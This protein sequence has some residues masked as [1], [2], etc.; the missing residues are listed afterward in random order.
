M[1]LKW[2]EKNIFSLVVVHGYP[3]TLIDFFYCLEL[4]F[5]HVNRAIAHLTVCKNQDEINTII[6]G[7]EILCYA[8][9]FSLNKYKRAVKEILAWVKIGTKIKK[10]I[11]LRD[12]TGLK[13]LSEEVL[14]NS[15][16]LTD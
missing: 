8:Q 4:E 1:T 2:S 10:A 7:L 13:I 6:R 3:I 16:K 9:P 5:I 14:M 11:A 12:V 15:I